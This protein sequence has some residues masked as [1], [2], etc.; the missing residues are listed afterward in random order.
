MN[1]QPSVS[2]IIP[3]KTID[4]YTRECI[5]RCKRLDY[6]T[7]SYEIIVLPD[8]ESLN[9][10]SSDEVKIIST[11]PL[12][13]GAKRNIAS[14]VARG[15][16]LA[17]VDSDAYPRKDW[18]SNA[19]KYLNDEVVAVGGPGITPPEDSL[20]QKASG[21]VLSSLMVGGLSRR[22]KSKSNFY[23]DDIHSCNFVTKR[24]IIKEVGGWNEKYWPGEDTLLCLEIERRGK[25]MFEAS[26][27]VVYHHRKPLLIPHL[28][29]M[30]RFG[31][32]RGFF[33][34]K[35]KGN[36]IKLTYFFPSLLVAFVFLGSLV[37]LANSFVA[38]LF[39]STLAMYAF[40]NLLAT[41]MQT[42]DL[43]LVPIV[44]TGIVLTHLIYGLAFLIGLL[45]SE[46]Q[47]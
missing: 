4:N 20:M 38:F 15:E 34:K 5:Y 1:G 9:F 44:L 42:R 37:S 40:L 45:K 31:L 28:R 17:Y 8:E 47:T 19:V 14:R 2:I 24:T 3:C 33:A 21:L 36:S 23:S 7:S 10:N 16:I 26:D 12:L 27:V 35:F 32:H 22:Y 43:K 46:L 41:F 13:P 30:F 11:G 39:L 25:N 29:Q 18:L 6:P